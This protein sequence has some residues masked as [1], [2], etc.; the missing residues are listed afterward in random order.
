[1]TREMLVMVGAEVAG[2]I[3]PGGSFA[4][5]MIDKLAPKA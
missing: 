4:V 5:R 1:M 2:H 3:I